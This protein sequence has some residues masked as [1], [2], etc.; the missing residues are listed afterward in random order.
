MRMWSEWHVSTTSLELSGQK[1]LSFCR[2]LVGVG[3]GGLIFMCLCMDVLHLLLLYGQGA[4]S[5]RVGGCALS[6][7]SDISIY[8]LHH[9]TSLHAYQIPLLKQCMGM[10][11]SVL[12]INLNGYMCILYIL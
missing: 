12:F 6:P 9:L 1:T 3:G 5:V 11:K 2:S 10:H 4:F 8:T 7:L